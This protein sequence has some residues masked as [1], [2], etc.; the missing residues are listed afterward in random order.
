MNIIEEIT[1]CKKC[2]LW[3]KMP[4]SPVP[5]VGDGDIM[6]LAECPGKDESII[7]EPLV[8]RCSKFFDR[9]VLIPA[10]LSR[11]DLIITNLVKCACRSGNK[12]RVPSKEEINI[13]SDWI[14]KEIDFYQPK[15]IITMGKYATL[16]IVNNQKTI[17]EL[18]RVNLKSNFK[19]KNI[20]GQSYL[21][22]N[23][24]V[25][26]VYHPSFLMVHS[27]KDIDQ[28][29]EIFKLIKQKFIC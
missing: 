7:M 1:N 9:Q 8:G 14:F 2:P 24:P 12:N 20:I 3:K 25:Y 22:N 6:V 11:K 21:Y 28:T 18:G 15:V 10:E 4:I 23:I 29:V 17:K 27:R 5:P 13:C 26:P 16:A 19:L